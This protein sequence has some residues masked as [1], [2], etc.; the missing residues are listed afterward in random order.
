[1]PHQRQPMRRYPLIANGMIHLV[2]FNFHLLLV[3]VCVCGGAFEID[4]GKCFE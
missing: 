1:M 3:C 2:I 4:F